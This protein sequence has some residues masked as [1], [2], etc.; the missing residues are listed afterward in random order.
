MKVYDVI[1]GDMRE[2]DLLQMIIDP[3]IDLTLIDINPFNN[4]IV[5]IINHLDHDL[6]DL[7]SNIDR[8]I[9]LIQTLTN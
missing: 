6:H 7:V 4:R 5:F 1:M 3:I 9:E 2:S 8:D